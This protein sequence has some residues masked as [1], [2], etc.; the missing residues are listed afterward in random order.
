MQP[1]SGLAIRTLR[2]LTCVVLLCLP[3]VVLAQIACT[4]TYNAQGMVSVI[5]NP[6]GQETRYTYDAAGR[7]SQ[8]TAPNGLV[9]AYA[10][11]PRGRLLSGGA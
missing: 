1:T 8:E 5:T 10:Y 7:I 11:D 6:L 9:T 4:C 2:R 3:A